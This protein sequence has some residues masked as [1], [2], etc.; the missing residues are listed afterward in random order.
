MLPE[1]TLNMTQNV[2]S[3]FLFYH[4]LLGGIQTLV[5]KT[6]I[7]LIDSLSNEI[8]SCYDVVVKIFFEFSLAHFDQ[9]LIFL[10]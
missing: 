8:K 7:V 4:S 2:M 6:L 10:Y 9:T 5:N 1:S 3:S